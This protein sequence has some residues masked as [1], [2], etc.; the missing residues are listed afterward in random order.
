MCRLFLN[1]FEAVCV[2]AVFILALPIVVFA[3]EKVKD[4]SPDGQFAMSLK[5]EKDG[6][7]LITLVEA[8]THKFVTKLADSGH[9]FADACRILWSPDSKRFAF[10]EQDRK[11][12]WTYVYIRK[13]SG[14]EMIELPELPE[15]DHPGLTGFILS[16]LTPKSWTKPDTLVLAAHDEWESEDGKS[17]E[18]DRTVTVAIDASGK[19]AIQSIHE[20]KKK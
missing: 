5:D 1:R 6:E 16:N 7:V 9:G 17:H 20:D 3:K 19:P 14:F 12:E 15:C 18:C 8:K 10:V 11:R 13:D 4:R 2:A